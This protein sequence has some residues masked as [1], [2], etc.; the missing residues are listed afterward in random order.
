MKIRDMLKLVAE[1]S[2]TPLQKIG[3]FD[4]Q[5]YFSPEQKRLRAIKKALK[6]QEEAKK[7]LAQAESNKV[8]TEV[9]VAFQSKLEKLE[10]TIQSLDENK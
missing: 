4:P 3:D 10:T 1:K 7:L 8:D 5:L 9:R 2:A 6:A